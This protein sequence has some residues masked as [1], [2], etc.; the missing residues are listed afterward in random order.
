MTKNTTPKPIDIWQGTVE[1]IEHD[2]GVFIS[3]LHFSNEKDAADYVEEV[4]I[5]V[6][7]L[8]E[9]QR[10]KLGD[11]M[12]FSCTVELD[13]GSVNGIHDVRDIAFLPKVPITPAIVNEAIKE[14]GFL[15]ESRYWDL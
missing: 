7:S 4:E 3:N 1:W 10:A 8:S 9:V 14:F 15:A 13:D 6:V 11:F 12:R 5:S 2:K